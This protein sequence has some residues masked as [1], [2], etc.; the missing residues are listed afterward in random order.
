MIGYG[1]VGRS[2]KGQKNRI[3]FMDGPLGLEFLESC[4]LFLF[5]GVFILKAFLC[6]TSF[7]FA[8]VFI[9]L[10]P[11]GYIIKFKIVY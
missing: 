1:W 3:S 8:K 4:F 11:K 10:S 5:Y 7:K 2:K 6:P 9:G